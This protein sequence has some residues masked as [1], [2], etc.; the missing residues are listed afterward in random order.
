MYGGG[1]VYPGQFYGD[2][3][4]EFGGGGSVGVDTGVCVLGTLVLKKGRELSPVLVFLVLG[5]EFQTL[6]PCYTADVPR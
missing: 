3:F 4:G 1:L 5:R 2:T 6:F